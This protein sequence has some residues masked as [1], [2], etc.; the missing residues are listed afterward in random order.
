MWCAMLLV[1]VVLLTAC[2]NTETSGVD[3][4]EKSNQQTDSRIATAKDEEDSTVL[5]VTGEYAPYTSEQYRNG[6]FL[7][8]VVSAVLEHAGIP[9]RVEFYPWARCSDMVRNGEAWA[10]FPYG[11]SADLIVDYYYTD[12]VFKSSH[13][14][15]YMKDNP[16]VTAKVKKY[17]KLSEFGS[18]FVFGGSND[19]WYGDYESFSHYDFEV[20]WTNG[21]DGLVKMLEAGR[22]DF[23][24]E[25]EY[26]GNETIGRLFPAKKDNFTTLDADAKLVDYFLLASA[27]YPDSLELVKKFNQSIKEMRSSG[28]L[29]AILRK[30]GVQ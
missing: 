13:K 26:V 14:F 24:I 6:G 18:E 2:K 23:F 10:A 22:I 8:K 20:E 11:Y 1:A 3:T 19:Y 17:S 9:Y 15:Y 4:K 12:A 27:K 28:E 29:D 7:T 25:D 16:K 21:T 30:S 5:L